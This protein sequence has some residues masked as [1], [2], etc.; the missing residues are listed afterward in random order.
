MSSKQF[1]NISV[2][3]RINPDKFRDFFDQAN[4]W[5]EILDKDCNVVYL[6]AFAQKLSGYSTGFFRDNGNRWQLLFTNPSTGERLKRICR[7]LMLLEKEFTE[8]V[9]AIKNKHGREYTMSWSMNLVRDDKGL[10]NGC[11]MAGI[12]V[13]DGNDAWGEVFANQEKYRSI[14]DHAPLGFF[15]SLPEGKFLE[16]N[17]TLARMLGFRQADEVL[18][19]ISNIGDEVYADPG[20]REG[21]LKQILH[22]EGIRSFE[23][24][25]RKKDGTVFD[26]RLNMSARHDNELSG[27]V[28]EG[29]VEDITDRKITENQL[30]ENLQKY[31]NLFENSPISIW[32]VDLS[33]VYE[34]VNKLKDNGVHDVEAYLSGHREVVSQCGRSIRVLDVNQATLEMFEVSTKAELFARKNEI[35][36]DEGLLA[37]IQ[38]FTAIANGQRSFSLETVYKTMKGRRRHAIIRW[39]LSTNSEKPFDRVLVSMEDITRQKAEQ[40]ALEKSEKQLSSL[41][42][43]LDDIVLRTDRNGVIQYLAPTAKELTIDGTLL[44]TGRS[45]SEYIDEETVKKM[46][47]MISSSLSKNKTIQFEHGFDFE[48][49]KVH[50]DIKI[51]PV[52]EANVIWVCRD[53][54]DRIKSEKTN[55]VMLNITRSVNIVEN[56]D[57]LFEDIRHE[58]SKLIDTKN[59]FIA[60]YDADNNTL[61]LPY[62]R[63]EKDSFDSFP[64][65]KTVSSLVLKKK[66]S[67]LLKASD[68]DELAG[69][70]EIQ[71]VGTLAKVWLGVPLMVE[72]EVI[73]IMVVQNY[74]NEHAFN[75]HDLEFLEV[76]SPQISLSIKRKQSE[77]L[78]RDSEKQLRESNLT[79]DRFFNIIA[80]DLKNPFNAIIGFSTLLTDEWL[81]FQDNEKLMMINSIRSSSEGAYELLMNLLEWS[82]LQVG[83]INFDPEFV[84]ISTLVDL[85]YSLLKTNAEHKNI[86][87]EKGS[88]C[89]R[90]VWADPN[91]LN[92]VL[93]NLISNAIKFTPNNGSIMVD[94]GKRT[95]H[96]NMVVLSVTDSGVGIPQEEIPD[97]F[98]ITSSKTTTGTA[99]ETGTGLGLVLCKEFIEKNNG[100]IW[101]ES[102]PEKGSVFYVALPVKPVKVNPWAR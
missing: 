77:Q 47:D 56:L 54:T 65:E 1:E 28:L 46:L 64:A 45:I 39:V 37:E 88:A 34:I 43:A 25:F 84:D 11:M 73:G 5:L 13:S 9:I 2:T 101:L 3:H 27:T 63:D 23:T 30:Q 68:V 20:F 79:K 60:L 99:G 57:S 48:G 12:K 58:L 67:M 74:D 102:R 26:I 36:T 7:N 4:V 17:T 35:I 53:I 71:I 69:K 70:G 87:L 86:R 59:F 55:E 61:S 96:P 33:E 80:H 94:C 6:N 22:A 41:F 24:K 51:S 98:D 85:N 32:E 16:V 75:R 81:E 8:K 44:E 29:T 50:Y 15:R 52:S 83:K 38:S 49:R 42:S 62:F 40:Q 97:L 10:V 91:M 95:D 14:F 90:L 78:L 72:G 31:T 89:D 66:T 19:Y 92:T 21:I 82:R 93:R 76:I 18:D 100:K